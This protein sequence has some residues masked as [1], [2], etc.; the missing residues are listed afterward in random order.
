MSRPCA[1]VLYYLEGLEGGPSGAVDKKDRRQRQALIDT[2][3]TL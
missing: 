1:L 3:H 2:S